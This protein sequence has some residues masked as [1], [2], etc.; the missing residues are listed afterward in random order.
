MKTLTRYYSLLLFVVA[1]VVF[2]V[3]GAYGQSVPASHAPVI[4]ITSVLR[5]GTKIWGTLQSEQGDA[6][7]VYDFN[8]GEVR[9]AKQDVST[10]VRESATDAAIVETVNNGSYFGFITDATATTLRMK[11]EV[12]GDFEIQS[13]S[14]SRIILSGSYVSKRGENWFSNPNATRYF[15][16]PSAIPLKK[17]EGY[18]QNAYLLANSVNI[19]VTN[20]MSIGGGVV[21]PFLFY[22]TPKVSYQLSRYIYA[23]AGILVTQA[24]VSNLNLSAGIGYGIVTV[25]N[26]EHNISL[27][28]G[29]GFAKM[30]SSYK[31]TRA[32]ILTINGMTRISK[33]MSI[34][35]ENWIIPRTSY[36]REETAYEP[37]GMAYTEM[38]PVSKNYYTFAGS[39]GMRI[40]PGIKTS[41]D[42]S[43]VGFKPNPYQNYLLLPY[44][45][46]VYKFN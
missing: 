7:V 19:G 42:F 37:N 11:S 2:S 14:I 40:M 31:A 45:D 5:D 44:L 20:N 21:I 36:N 3:S 43:V 17:K 8:L 29:Y 10:E 46:F 38:I 26:R 18:F 12:I 24:F 1:I 32:P 27:E 28:V 33:K 15:F 9:Y 16:A 22:I 25:G 34:V 6:Y 30:D 23:G 35:I 41:V 13:S 39:L 4:L